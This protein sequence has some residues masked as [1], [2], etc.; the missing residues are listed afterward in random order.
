[1]IILPPELSRTRRCR[2]ML[3]LSC[4]LEIETLLTPSAR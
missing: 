3:R 2:R 1:V 4:E